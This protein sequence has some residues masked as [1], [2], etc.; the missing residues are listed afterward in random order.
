MLQDTFRHAAP[1]VP[2]PELLDGPGSWQVTAHFRTFDLDRL[3]TDFDYTRYLT[4]NN[5]LK[6]FTAKTH[7]CTLM[8]LFLKSCRG[9]S[10]KNASSEN[11]QCF[12]KTLCLRLTEEWRLSWWQCLIKDLMRC[13][14]ME[15]GPLRLCHIFKGAVCS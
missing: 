3:S 11:E 8:F 10:G 4:I 12:H 6:I 9:T 1:G 5:C 7:H 13:S 14:C 2:R 15:D